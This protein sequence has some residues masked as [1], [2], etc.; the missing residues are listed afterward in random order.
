MGRSIACNSAI[1]TMHGLWHAYR[2][3]HPPLTFSQHLNLDTYLHLLGHGLQVGQR[4]R[5]WVLALPPALN[6][7][8]STL[9]CAAKHRVCLARLVRSQVCVPSIQAPARLGLRRLQKAEHACRCERQTPFTFPAKLYSTAGCAGCQQCGAPYLGCTL[10]QQRFAARAANLPRYLCQL[11]NVAQVHVVHAH[12]LFRLG[13]AELL[14][15][16]AQH[17]TQQPAGLGSRTQLAPDAGHSLCP[18]WQPLQRPA[19]DLWRNARAH[20][21][22]AATRAPLRAPAASP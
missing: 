13:R 11:L 17:G 5:I 9:P 21:Q 22:S 14:L 10:V 20:L 2:I 4:C 6:C 1:A 15:L 3:Q 12:H 7:H 19:A 18:A 16:N 8:C